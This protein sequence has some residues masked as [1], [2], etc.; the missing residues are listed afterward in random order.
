M[1]Q[2]VYQLSGSPREDDRRF[3]KRQPY[4]VKQWIAPASASGC[5]PKAA[6]IEVPCHDL[7]GGGFSFFLAQRPT[8]RHLVAALGKPTRLVYLT[9]EVVHA[10]DVLLYASGMIEPLGDRARHVSY[11]GPDGTIGAPRVLVGCRFT[12]RPDDR[13]RS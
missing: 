4:R 2:L 6:F 8:F 5:P 9:A 13:A 11:E 10:D 7:S 1:Y 3:S 12:G